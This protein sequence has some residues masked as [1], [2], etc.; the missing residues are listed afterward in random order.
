M[1]I[2]EGYFLM[3]RILTRAGISISTSDMMVPPSRDAVLLDA[4]KKV[5]QITKQHA[6]GAISEKERYNSVV[7]V[8]TTA[9]NTI[10]EDL[11]SSR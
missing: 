7:D 8:W 11:S 9:T 3:E 10:S 4:Q 6:A 1:F 5:N 2:Q